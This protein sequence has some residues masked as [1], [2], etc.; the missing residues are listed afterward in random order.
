[1][2]APAPGPLLVARIALGAALLAGAGYV[3]SLL[4][5][6][7]VAWPDEA[8]FSA[9]AVALLRHGHLGTDPMAPYLPG[10]ATRTYWVPPLYFVLLALVFAVA[11]AGLAAMRAFTAVT[12]AAALAATWSLGRKAGL[13]RA[14]ACVAPALLAVDGV[15]LRGA[16]VGRMDMLAL[17]LT[18]AAL[19]RALALRA[20]GLRRDGVLA[21]L[22][23]GLATITH[24][25]GAVAPAALALQ[26]LWTPQGERRRD[27]GWLVSGLA[28]PLVAWGLYVLRDP[29]SFA[30][31]YGAQLARKSGR[32]PWS[33]AFFARSLD[34]SFSQ[35]RDASTPAAVV[36]GRAA[37]WLWA[38]GTVGLA[39]GAW[40]RPAVRL[41]LAAHLLAAVVTLASAEMWYPLFVLPTAAL[42][43]GVLFARG[44]VALPA[45][46]AALAALAALCA[47]FAGQNLAREEALRVRC[48]DPGAATDYRAWSAGVGALL[49]RGAT[50]FVGV[51][52]DVTPGLLG[53]ADLRFRTFVPEGLPVPPGA[54]R[55]GFDEAGYVVVGPDSPGTIADALAPRLGTLVGVVGTDPAGYRAAVYRMPGA[56]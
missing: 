46:P 16:R 54:V 29:A 21:G 23:A 19:E 13:D 42:G 56:P 49:P 15:F 9:P 7:P 5:F 12:A 48:T 31:Q 2:S 39:W 33:L 35:Y 55:R 45:R 25:L 6:D 38:L 27:L 34:L 4:L 47:C 40:R 14:A 28:G 30:A 8:L 37:A 22:F 26:L 10:I 24:P 3:A 20:T 51:F 1:M 11:G 43:V 44:L 41:L 36:P 17:A 18:L 53:R 52:P 32:D 50:V